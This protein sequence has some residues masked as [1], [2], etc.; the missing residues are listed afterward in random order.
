MTGLASYLLGVLVM[1][2]LTAL[3]LAGALTLITGYVVLWWGILLM[4]VKIAHWTDIWS[5]S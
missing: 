1:T 4:A 3:M 2:G 5:N